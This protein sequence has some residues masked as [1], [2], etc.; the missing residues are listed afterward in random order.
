MELVYL[1]LMFALSLLAFIVC[2]SPVFASILDDAAK[3]IERYREGDVSLE[4]HLS[5]GT[6]TQNAKVRIEQT[7]H[8][9]YFGNYMRPRHYTN[10]AYLDRFRELF[11][12]IQ[13]LEFNW[14]QYEPD[15]GKPLLTKRMN[16]I[17]NW[18]TPNDF[19]S[20]Y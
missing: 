18:C 4:F 10:K 1:N 12:F 6:K 7:S 16:F 13:L 17:N 15:E 8:D 11:N 20:F 2:C 5:D 14:G 9:F 3:N 19:N